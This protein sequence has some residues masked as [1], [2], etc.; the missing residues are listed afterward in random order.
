MTQTSALLS[1]KLILQIVFHIIYWDTHLLRYALFNDFFF[2]KLLL[3]LTIRLLKHFSA[4]NFGAT[5]AVM[6]HELTHAF[7]TTGK[8][9]LVDKT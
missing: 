8:N 9:E 2:Y 6:G 1:I 3:C 7:D 4:L 5:G